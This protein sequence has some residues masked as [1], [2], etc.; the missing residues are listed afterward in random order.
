[1][2]KDSLDNLI[3]GSQSQEEEEGESDQE[4]D[5]SEKEEMNSYRERLKVNYSP[6][7]RLVSS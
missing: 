3:G 4:N 7:S 2:R 1:M 6:E 5:F